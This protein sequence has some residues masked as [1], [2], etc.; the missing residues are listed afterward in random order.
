MKKIIFI[1]LGCC[2]H[3]LS[4][5]QKDYRQGYI[6]TIQKDTLLGLI[7]Y[8]ENA[9]NYE[10]C[11]FKETNTSSPIL[12]SPRD[13]EGYRFL[14]DKLF[15]AKKLSEKKISNTGESQDIFLEVLV[16][17]TATLYR[18]KSTFFI[19]KGADNFHELVN[20]REVVII[21]EKKVSR[22]S[23]KYVGILLFLLG[24]CAELKPQ[25]NRTALNEKALTKLVERYNACMGSTPSITYKE[26]KPWIK[27]SLGISGGVVLSQIEFRSSSR[28]DIHYEQPFKRSDS[29]M[30]GVSVSFTFPRFNER[31]SVITDAWYVSNTY[32]SFSELRDPV[33]PI[34]TRNDV[35]IQIEQLKIPAG[36]RYT[37]PTG[38]ISPFVSFGISRTFHHSINSF[39][40]REE[41]LNSVVMTWHYEPIRPLFTS[42]LRE[43]KNNQFGYW[44]GT[45]I[46][47]T[48]AKKFLIQSEIRYEMTNGIHK[49]LFNDESGSRISNLQ[50]MARICF[51]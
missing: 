28:F 44:A 9:K 50:I 34:I 42:V 36:F 48:F 38:K 33:I 27:S 21:E 40:I 29:F 30:G 51:K 1:L 16:K 11:E 14:D 12:Y 20:T 23:N 7:H 25:I 47:I 37:F 10:L 18:Y 45:G 13:L 2:L 24:D 39:W 22:N 43:F 26:N 5:A 31:L 49:G 6:V 46:N 3:H 17:G 15:V 35:F 41:E 8:R 32:I 4:Y 19:E